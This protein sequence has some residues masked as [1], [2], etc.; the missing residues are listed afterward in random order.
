MH[1]TEDQFLARI[2]SGRNLLNQ[3][4]FSKPVSEADASNLNEA[5]SVKIAELVDEPIEES[6]K[7]ESK[8]SGRTVGATQIP[9]ALRGI[10]ASHTTLTSSVQAARDFGIS[11]SAAYSMSQGY[12]GGMAPSNNFDQKIIDKR[13]ELLDSAADK[14]MDKMLLAIGL[15]NNDNLKDA[16]VRDISAVAK[17][18]A[19]IVEKVRAKNDD[20]KKQGNIV[21]VA[22][23]LR[24][25][26]HFQVVA[27]VS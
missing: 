12:R 18:M 19:S 7:Q 2:N 25:E 9:D 24:D 13:N 22:P 3:G 17:D 10:I 6:P 16:K 20:G 14:A 21:I 15:I 5:P 4:E 8:G 11:T 26:S 23:T 1:L 27:A